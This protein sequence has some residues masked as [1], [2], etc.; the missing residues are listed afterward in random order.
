MHRRYLQDEFSRS[1]GF[2]RVP[3]VLAG[4]LCSFSSALFPH[5]N[6]AFT[7]CHDIEETRAS[8]VFASLVVSPQ[9][10]GYF[11][12]PVQVLGSKICGFFEPHAIKDILSLLI[13]AQ[14][15][16]Q[17]GWKQVDPHR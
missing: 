12:H 5:L 15:F 14:F 10:G 13:S 1:I 4:T 2:I 11:R 8:V 6:K 3:E 9:S 17:H 7:F 16:Q